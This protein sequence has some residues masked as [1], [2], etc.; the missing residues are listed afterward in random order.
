M[1]FFKKHGYRVPNIVGREF[2]LDNGMF[3]ERNR[4]G[5]YP[6][7]LVFWDRGVLRKVLS[8]E[9]IK[10]TKLAQ[11]EYVINIKRIDI[12]EA[13]FYS[14]EVESLFGENKKLEFRLEGCAER[15]VDEEK[16]THRKTYKH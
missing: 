6:M 16:E 11:G 15:V 12:D 4:E 7:K 10:G 3:Q 9:K 1:K 8:P 5:F 14:L 2:Y 13:G